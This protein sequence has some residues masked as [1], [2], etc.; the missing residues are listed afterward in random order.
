MKNV[1]FV[2]TGNT[3]RSPMA[4]AIFN[5]ICEKNGLPHHARSAGVATVNGI[6][7]AKNAIETMANLGIDLSQHKARFLPDVK[8]SD[9]DLFVTMNYDQ[10]TLVESLGVPRELI[11]VL[12]KAP[13]D[14][15]DIEIGI[16]DPFGG[17]MLAYKKCAEDLKVTIAELIKTL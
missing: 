6:P 9:Y 2:C 8:L 4:E 10:A 3:C 14:K 17:D 16:A 11:R 13:T 1:L 15:Y 12:E 5:D 7:A